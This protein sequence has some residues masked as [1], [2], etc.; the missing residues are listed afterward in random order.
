[1]SADD[2]QAIPDVGPKVSQSIYDWF[3][4]KRNE[5][6]IERL[7]KVGIKLSTFHLPPST[8]GK[9]AGKTFVLTGTLE[10]MSRDE[11]KEKIR[12]LGGEVS[13]SVSKKT[14]YV[15]TG[16]EPGI[17]AEKA[18]KLGVEILIEKKFI[19]LLK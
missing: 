3:R 17:K 8:S 14:S 11:A 16:A 12:A 18:E 19:E 4:V 7:E 1:M 9:L 6:L 10:S 15:V 13:E 5:R 2:L